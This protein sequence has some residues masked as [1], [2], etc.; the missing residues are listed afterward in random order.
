M[1]SIYV[2]A[3]GVAAAVVV[4][5]FVARANA[6]SDAVSG[7]TADRPVTSSAPSL[8]WD[9]YAGAVAY[10]VVRDRTFLGTVATTSF[11]DAALKAD[12]VH[13]YRVWAVRADGTWS[14][15]A[16][17]Q[18]T[19]DTEA[20]VSITSR[21][22]GA[23][24]TNGQPTIVWPT[25]GDVGPAGIKQYNIR[26]NGVFI[27]AVPADRLSFT[28][29]SVGEGTY[30][31]IVRAEDRAGNKAANFSPQAVITVDR[32]APAAPTGLTADTASGT[33]QLAWRASYDRSAVRGYRILRDGQAVGSVSDT[34]FTD[35]PPAGTYSYT[36]VAVDAAGNPS[37][38]S[39]AV[40]ATVTGHGTNGGASGV[41]LVTGNDQ[42]SS[43]KSHWPDAKIISITVRWSQLEPSRGQFSW[44]N[45]DASL[46]DAAARHYRVI[47]RILAGF[48][49]PAW[50]YTDPQ[51]PVSSVYIIPTDD[52]YGLKTGVHVPVPWD[53]DLLVLYRQMMSAVGD[54]LQ[55]SDGLGGRL[56]DHVYMIPVAMATSF[57]SEMVTNFG[58]GTWAG[59]YNGTYSSSWNRNPVNQAAWLKVAP[60]G[61]TTAEKLDAMRRAD[62]QAWLA[63]IDAQESILQPTGIMSSVAYGFAFNSFETATTVEATEV[64]KYGGRLL[65]M[66]TNL[67]PKVNADGSLGPWGAWCPG[68]D[69]LVKA[70]IADGGPVGFQT[71]VSMMKTPARIETATNAAITAYHPRFVETVGCVVGADY[72]YFFTARDNVQ[73]RLAAWAGS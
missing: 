49:T 6:A 29:R 34:T 61:S 43:M 45:L 52:G 14:T 53:P 38:P 72:G 60:S 70:A 17:T 66:F 37:S 3:A 23:R 36:V 62:T 44:G 68:C 39:R 24:L 56:A 4:A 50:A 71:A 5:V 31:Y 46:K 58:Q 2:R 64:P 26:R 21:L 48:N 40:R 19:Y 67:Q 73:A 54:H 41:S 59:T 27:A 12:G 16:S 51:N 33:V 13:T 9:A 28:D 47:V 25:V 65:T 20:P 15:V 42:S 1:G 7:L 8:H 32:T 11:T 63:S 22:G 69:A 55:G 35:T 30:T 57:G 18:V 10:R